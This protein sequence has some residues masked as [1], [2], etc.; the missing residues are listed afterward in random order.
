VQYVYC[1]GKKIMNT[2]HTE[3]VRMGTGL[4]AA[5]ARIRR[6]LGHHLSHAQILTVQLS[7]NHI[8]H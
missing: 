1:I 2:S 5:G 4:H 3:C 7:E 6:C 8:F